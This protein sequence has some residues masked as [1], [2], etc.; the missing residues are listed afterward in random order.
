MTL[1]H[2]AAEDLGRFVEGTLDDAARA[3][4]VEHIADCDECRM[5]VVDTSEFVEPI[6][7][8]SGRRWLL[9]V[10]AAILV[11]VGGALLW[12]TS[13]NLLTPVIQASSHLHSRSVDGRLT[14][15]TYVERITTR[16]GNDEESPDP[17]Q[18]QLDGELGS[19]LD[20]QG[21]D[22]RTLHAKGIALLVK[23]KPT[24]EEKKQAVALLQ[25]AATKEQKASNLSDLAV[26][27]IAT[28]TT[29]NLERAIDVCNRAL[30]INDRSAE[31]LFNRAKALQFLGRTKEAIEAY[32][33]YLAVDSSSP[34]A[35][36]A[37]KNIDVLRPLPPS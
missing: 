23:S 31:A 7:A 6:A 4:L 2:P 26:A 24:A 19:I 25:E 21:T 8:H 12:T 17:A 3:A 15:F 16:S 28:G 11:A 9:P 29:D 32:Q 22:P 13:R 14:G 34:W 10:A 36:E 27:L 37:R 18:W 33:E 35:D 30:Q 1:A 5:V 20:R